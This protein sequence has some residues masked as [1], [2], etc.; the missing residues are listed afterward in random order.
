M[1]DLTLSA[2][3]EGY[4]VGTDGGHVFVSVTATDAK[5]W[6]ILRANGVA[7]ANEAT[8]ALPAAVRATVEAFMHASARYEYANPAHCPADDGDLSPIC[9]TANFS[10]M[11]YDE[12]PVCVTEDDFTALPDEDT[13]WE[14]RSIIA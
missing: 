12:N 3:P 9:G 7:W 5:F 13:C 14:C 6:P 11:A 2:L 4:A 10:R 8:F 1:R